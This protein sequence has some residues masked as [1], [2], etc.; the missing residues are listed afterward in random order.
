MALFLPLEESL[1]VVVLYPAVAE[2]AVL[3]PLLQRLADR[4]RGLDLHIRHPQRE[5]IGIAEDFL[6]GIPLQGPGPLAFHAI[7]LTELF[8]IHC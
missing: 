3:H 4:G 2:D 5:Q 8:E 6:E 7:V 1:I